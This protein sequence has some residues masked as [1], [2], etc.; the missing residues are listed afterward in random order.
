LNGEE[1]AT[2]G[3]SEEADHPENAWSEASQGRRMA[4]LL[5]RTDFERFCRAGI[6]NRCYQALAQAILQQPGYL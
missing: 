3:V 1:I 4:N 6:P 5:Q 2:R